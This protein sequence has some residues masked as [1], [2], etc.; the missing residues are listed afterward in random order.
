MTAASSSPSTAQSIVFLNIDDVI[1]RRPHHNDIFKKARELFGYSTQLG[2]HHLDCAAASLF[3]AQAVDNLQ[4]LIYTVRNVAL[5]ITA[6]WRQ[7]LQTHQLQE[8]LVLHNFSHRIVDMTSQSSNTAFKTYLQQT[9][10][11][12]PTTAL[13]IAYWLKTHPEV[14]NFVIYDT[15]TGSLQEKFPEHYV[16]VDPAQLLSDENIE[17]GLKILGTKV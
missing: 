11:I 5:V 17:Q 14:K 12:I 1:Y 3:N 10:Y 13:E 4:R 7:N 9:G 15:T 6:D 8:R 16:K 2:E